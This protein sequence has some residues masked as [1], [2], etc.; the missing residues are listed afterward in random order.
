M[1]FG[2]IENPTLVIS[3]FLDANALF[4]SQNIIFANLIQNL[5]LA[6]F[7]GIYVTFDESMHVTFDESNPSSAKKVVVE[8][9]VDE[10][11]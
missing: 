9:D 6:S 3:K 11:L 4:W 7:L 8:N 10:E 2:K 1:S 5:M